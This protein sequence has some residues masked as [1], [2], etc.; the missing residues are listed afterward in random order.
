MLAPV[1]AQ[2]KALAAR[3]G[4]ELCVIIALC[5]TDLDPQGYEKQK[6]CLEAAGAIVLES[7]EKASL[8]AREILS[9]K[10]EEGR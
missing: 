9:I 8:L 5:G 6:A 3:E 10:K 1:I 2:N 4:R 7:N